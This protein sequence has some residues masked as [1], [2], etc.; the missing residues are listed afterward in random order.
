M[1]TLGVVL[2]LLLAAGP[3]PAAFDPVHRWRTI[4]T[5]H[6]AVIFHEGCDE[7]AA[8]A[9][10]IAEAAHAQLAPRVG[11][12]PGE[13]TRLIIADDD[14]AAGGWASPYPYN[15]IMITPTPPLGEFGLGTT[16]H[17]DWLRLVITHE[18]THILQLDMTAGLPQAARSIFGRLYF[19]NA[20]QPLWLIEGLATL[21]ETELTA[22]GRGHSPGSAMFLRMAALAGSLPTLDQMAV[23][24]DAWPAGQVPYLFGES[25]LRYLAGRFG[26]EKI[27]ALSRVYAGRPL[28]FLVESSGREALGVDYRT[29]WGQWAAELQQQ[30]RALE[31]TLAAAGLTASSA[32]TAAGR[33]NLA[34]AWSPDGRTIAWLRADGS[35]YPGVWV[36]NADGSGRRRL[37]KDAFSTTS[38]GA[39]LAWSPD[40]GRLYYTRQGIRR[41]TAIVND[42]WAWDFGRNREI[43]LTDGLRARDAA[44]SPDGRTLV[45]VTA[46]RGLT[47]LALADLDGP[48][49]LRGAAGV[50]PLTEFTADQLAG[51]RWSPDG[52][53]IA[54]SAWRPGGEQEI[55]V[56]ARDGSVLA[57]V[58]FPGAL[59]GAPAWSPDGGTLFFSSDVTGIFNIFA[60]DARTGA[61]AQVTNVLGGAFSPA[62]APDGRRLCFTEYTASGYDLRLM[63]LPA[64]AALPP[65]AIL[66]SAERQDPATR[67]GTAV[68]TA[69]SPYSPLDTL[70]PRF[71]FPWA[72]SSPASGLMLGLVTGGQDAVQRHRYTL[73]GLYGPESGRLMHWF[74]YRYSGLRPTLRLSSSDFD[75][76]YAGL[77]RDERRSADY[78]ERYRAVGAAVDLSFPGFESAQ[79]VSLGYRYRELSALDSLPPWPQYRGTLPATGAFGS[80]RLDWAFDNAWRQPLSISPA[81]GRRV[82]LRLERFQRGLGSEQNAT[83]ATLDW[84]E[85]VAL[86]APRHVLAARVFFG[87]MDGGLPQQGVFGLGGGSPGDVEVAADDPGLLLRGFAPNAFRGTRAALASLEYRFPLLEVGRGGVSAPLFL[88][89]LHGALFVDAG[90][91]WTGDAFRTRDVHAGAGAEI[92]FDLLFSYGLPL[93]VRLGVAVGLDGEGGLYPTLSVRFPQGLP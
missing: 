60:W 86:P 8:R 73:T 52:A 16:R 61:V 37:V 76:S 58:G 53:R 45:L 12:T 27:A 44:A 43:R 26:R 22:G 88:R 49:P 65:T 79:A 33:F 77:L 89:R 38:S 83:V 66:L 46:G 91:A 85:Y 92:R 57:H 20:L 50:R 68:L 34:A 70:L 25:F 90:E 14:D 21:E 28:P 39:T 9:A 87:G 80:L 23:L 54:V 35:D 72:A 75:R 40:G 30:S 82:E 84:S 59:D 4:R 32:L 19:P 51:P 63:D 13:R 1:R 17:D 62:P 10:T 15:Q 48:L 71:W 56:L 24:P 69:S 41:G 67:T 11:W 31:R 47:R 7:L 81:G 18:Y 5:A 2:L 93:T 29:L 3:A 55:R 42:L 74:D 64:A 36:M 6:F 78:T